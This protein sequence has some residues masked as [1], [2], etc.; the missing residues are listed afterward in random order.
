VEAARIAQKRGLITLPAGPEGRVL[1]LTPPAILT[2]DQVD[3]GL[4]VVIDAIRKATPT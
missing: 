1:E 3:Y 4:E 2:K